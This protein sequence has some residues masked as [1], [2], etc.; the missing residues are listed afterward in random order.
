MGAPLPSAC[1]TSVL[2]WPWLLKS[3]ACHPWPYPPWAGGRTSSHAGLSSTGLCA[4]RASGQISQLSA[5]CRSCACAAQ[6]GL[7]GLSM[8]W[9]SHHL[10][11][12][13]PSTAWGRYSHHIGSRGP[14]GTCPSATC[15]PCTWHGAFIGHRGTQ[16]FLHQCCSGIGTV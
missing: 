8:W 3:P 14:A 15:I 6:E 2:A 1:L 9:H 13:C 4:S 11:I 7:A 16:S 5:I 12:L 10:P